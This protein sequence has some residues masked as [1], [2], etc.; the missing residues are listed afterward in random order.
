M[1]SFWRHELFLSLHWYAKISEI[2]LICIF[3][4]RRQKQF[5]VIHQKKFQSGLSSR[6]YIREYGKYYI[7]LCTD[8]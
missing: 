2:D 5:W 8:I 4:I 3:S 1:I 6:W 7:E